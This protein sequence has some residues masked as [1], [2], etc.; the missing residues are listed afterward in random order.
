MR[1]RICV[2]LPAGRQVRKVRLFLH[3][4]T[5]KQNRCVQFGCFTIVWYIWVRFSSKLGI[6][7]N[8]NQ[9]WFFIEKWKMKLLKL[10][11]FCIRKQIFKN[12]WNKK[13]AQQQLWPIASIRNKTKIKIK[14]NIKIKS[15]VGECH[16]SCPMR[17]AQYDLTWRNYYFYFY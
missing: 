15:T 1:I 10:L 16:C 17:C 6:H 14:K 2:A 12:D 3:A 7:T 9:N 5:Y 8:F 13:T 4:A 11:E